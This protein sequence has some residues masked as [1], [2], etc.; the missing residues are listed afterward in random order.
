MRLNCTRDVF[1]RR[2]PDERWNFTGF[3]C[4]QA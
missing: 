3:Y 1:R 2:Q 4:C